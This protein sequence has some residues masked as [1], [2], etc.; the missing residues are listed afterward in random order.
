MRC[1]VDRN[2][3][4]RSFDQ[5]YKSIEQLIREA[6]GLSPDQMEKRMEWAEAEAA[7]DAPL[8]GRSIPNAPEHEFQTILSKMEARGITPRVMADFSRDQQRVLQSENGFLAAQRAWLSVKPD[9]VIKSKGL[10]P[11]RRE[12]ENAKKTF[13]SVPV[14]T[15]GAAAACV[16][17]GI[18]IFTLRP[19]IDVMG[20]RNYTYVSEVRD[21]EKT[22]IVWNNQENYIS[23]G[24]KLEEA[25]AEINETLGIKVL[26]VNY[27]PADVELEKVSINSGQ[28]R[29]TFSYEQNY[30][31]V[32]EV[33]Y[34][35]NNSSGRFSDGQQY[36][37]VFN[38]WLNRDISIQ[39]IQ[40][41]EEQYEY[42]AYLV[43]E[44][45][46]YYIHGAMEEEEFINI[47]ENVSF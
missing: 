44:N 12:S 24:G 38:E 7:S 1:N 31:Y 37:S 17:A 2:K 36:K 26:K 34:S 4:D 6:Y 42:S 22:D 20:K 29:L 21:G 33:L 5:Q 35:K 14:R 15:A 13:F 30:V 39:R 23:D 9:P 41:E 25:Y 28:A 11:G 45:A 43:I 10:G 8:G 27:L 18:A 32:L 40:Q 16:A 46:Y 3:K 19:G 47:I